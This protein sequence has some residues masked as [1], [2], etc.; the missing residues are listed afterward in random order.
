[1]TITNSSTTQSIKAGRS[2]QVRLS[3]VGSKSLLVK[4]QVKDPSGKSYQIASRTVEKNKSFS[5]PIMKFTKKGSYQVTI[6]LGTTKRV[7]TVKVA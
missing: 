5:T 6:L 2:L 4:V 3:T 7:V 1:L